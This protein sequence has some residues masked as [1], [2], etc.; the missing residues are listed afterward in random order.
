MILLS[1]SD[2]HVKYGIDIDETVCYNFTIIIVQI[3]ISSHIIQL[4]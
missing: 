4:M 1:F 2:K 3:I